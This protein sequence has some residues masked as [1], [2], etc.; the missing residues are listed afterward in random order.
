M[1]ARKSYGQFCALARALDHIG[2][3][4]TLL[5]VRELLIAPRSFQELQRAL[6]G[7]SPN[8]LVQRLRT[9]TKDGLA[10]RSEAPIRSKSVMFEL[11]PAGLALEAAV[12][13]LIRWGSRWMATGPKADHVDPAWL[14]LAIRA[15]LDGAPVISNAADTVHINADGHRL[16]IQT[17]AGMRRVEAGLSGSPDATVTAQMPA[18]LAV[19]AG[20]TV[21]DAI[22]VQIVGNRGAAATALSP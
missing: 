19:A 10:L 6:P 7:L 8:M 13:E 12:F 2:D 3:R 15:L 22:D 20:L 17:S 5:I 21:L 4:W 14:I 11:T 1:D 9:L 18:I 16:T